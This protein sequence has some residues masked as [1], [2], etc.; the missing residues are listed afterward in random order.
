MVGLALGVSDTDKEA[1]EPCELQKRVS[2]ILAPL[3]KSTHPFSKVDVALTSMGRRLKVTFRREQLILEER[4]IDYDQ[5][6]CLPTEHY[7]EILL[8]GFFKNFAPQ[9]NRV[10]PSEIIGRKSEPKAKKGIAKAKS[11]DFTK[12]SAGSTVTTT[13]RTT[14]L[15]HIQSSTITSNPDVSPRTLSAPARRT[16]SFGLFAHAE[17][18]LEEFAPRLGAKARALYKQDQMAFIA[19]V[20]VVEPIRATMN[21]ESL[22]VVPLH[23]ALGGGRCGTPLGLR[24][25]LFGVVGREHFSGEY[26]LNG[27]TKRRQLGQWVFEGLV[28]YQDTIAKNMSLHIGLSVGLRPKNQA[29]TDSNNNE[30]IRIS[31]WG[32]NTHIGVSYDVFDFFSETK[33]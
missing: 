19:R 8:K 9:P 24:L 5:S 14:T 13:T 31:G 2:K 23:Y 16:V 29:F 21:S 26:S 17:S 25:C 28:E 12:P 10:S 30:F 15:N 7:L 33:N 22:S 3:H 27:Q 11:V 1:N 32:G 20:G 18:P 4:F 6:A